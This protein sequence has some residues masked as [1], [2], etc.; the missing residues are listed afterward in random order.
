VF[1]PNLELAVADSLVS[2]TF[3]TNKKNKMSN[4]FVT[5]TISLDS[6]GAILISYSSDATTPN[7]FLTSQASKDS[8]AL[9]LVGSNLW[10]AFRGNSDPTLYVAGLA[11]W[12]ANTKVG[13]SSNLAPAL[14][15]YNNQ[16]W[17]AYIGEST[18][19]VELVSSDDGIHWSGSIITGQSSKL[20]PAITAFGNN[21][22]VAYIGETSGHVEVIFSANGTS[23]WSGITNTGQ[24][25]N[26]RP[27]MTVFG[28]NLWIAYIGQT[29]G[30][31]ELIYSADGIHW[32]AKIDTGQSSKLGP[33]LVVFQGN[34]VI[35]YYAEVSGELNGALFVMSSANGT[36]WPQPAQIGGNASFPCALA[37][38]PAATPP[39]NFG[40]FNQYVFSSPIVTGK[41]YVPL[42]DL[43]VQIFISEDI[44]VSPQS[45][46]KPG[47][48]VPQPIGFQINGFSQ[49]GDL[50]IGWQQYGITM[51]PGTNELSSFVETWPESLNTNA[52]APNVINLST[53]SPAIMPN[54]LTI[55]AGWVFSFEF[56]TQN[57]GFINALNVVVSD[58]G[59][60]L[61]NLNIDLLGQQLAAGGTIGPQDLAQLVAFQ[62]VLVG[63]ANSVGATLTSGAGTITCSS[64]TPMNISIPWPPDADG[65]NGTA[66]FAN[67]SYGLVPAESSTSI[68]QSF[69]VK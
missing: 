30:H 10:M 41:P 25:S 14:A 33:S 39:N 49:K 68:S 26:I 69:G 45:G 42:L 53:T 47:V 21:L 8:P 29:S 1:S 27:S 44:V 67:S 32:S 54:N 65:G 2:R 16:L 5:A 56:L 37:V 40:G 64:S 28:T 66:E 20:S 58:E 38:I 46:I 17:L 9:A 22:Y 60:T 15:G 12:G 51:N 62:V 48:T 34:L 19:R 3:L 61:A 63:W 23:N 18:S 31:V 4:L 6:P 55:P 35:C 43:F 59:Q 11:N 52:N 50:T 24:S 36:S 57:N 13:Q 7:N